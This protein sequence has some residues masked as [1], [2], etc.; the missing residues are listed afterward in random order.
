MCVIVERRWPPGEDGRYHPYGLC[1]THS[2]AYCRVMSLGMRHG[3]A[4]AWVGNANGCGG[5]TRRRVIEA[6]GLCRGTGAGRLMSFDEPLEAR[7]EGMACRER[8]RVSGRRV[9]DANGPARA[10]GRIPMDTVAAGAS[11]QYGK[12]LFDQN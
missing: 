10:V 12:M 5:W 3:E 2:T 7:V 1:L 9:E 6:V 4:D 8:P 11:E